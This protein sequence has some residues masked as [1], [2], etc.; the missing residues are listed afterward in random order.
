MVP[1]TTLSFCLLAWPAVFYPAIPVFEMWCDLLNEFKD[2]SPK[3]GGPF[4]PYI[5][6]SASKGDGRVRA[7]S[8]RRQHSGLQF[9]STLGFPGEGPE[10]TTLVSANI[11]SLNT[12]QLWKSWGADITCLQETRI[13]KNNVRT[14]TRNIEAVGLRP[15]L[16]QLLPGLWHA[17]GT[18]KTPCGGTA[19]LGPDVAITPFEPKHDQTG[20]FDCLFQTKRFAAAWYQVTSKIQALILCVYA[21]TG[22][23]SDSRVHKEN[24]KMFADIL[25]LVA[26]FGDIPVILS[27]DFQAVPA[28]YESLAGALNFHGWIDPLSSTDEWGSVTR[29]YTYSK[30]CSFSGA[31]EGCTSIDGVLLNKVAFCAMQDVHVLEHFGRQHRPIKVTFRWA[32][33]LQ[34]GF[35]LHKFA[36]ID[37]TQ[38]QAVPWSEDPSPLWQN[39]FEAAFH[40]ASDHELKWKV[41]NEFFQKSLLNEGGQWGKG[42]RVR[43][44]SPQFV[45]KRICPKQLVTR[46]AATQVSL[47]LY[48]LIRRLD[49]LFVRLSRESGSPQDVFNTKRLA[50]RTFNIVHKLTPSIVW[51]TPDSPTLVEVFFVRRWAEQFATTLDSRIR[52]KRIQSWK[53]KIQE[54]AQGGCAYIF[55]HLRQKAQDEPPNLVLDSAGQIITQPEDAIATPIKML[56][57]VWPYIHGKQV[58]ADL[59]P[60]SAKDLYQVI[61]RRKPHVAPGL[62]G[63]R[64]QE[65]QMLHPSCFHALALFFQSLEQSKDPLPQALVN[66]KQVILNKPGTASPMNKRLITIIPPLLLAY[67]GAR[68]AQLQ[69]WQNQAFPNAIVGGVKH[70]AMSSL[71]NE[72]RLEL[73]VANLDQETVCGIKIDKSKAFDRILPQFAACLFVAFGIPIYVVSVFLRFYQGLRKHMAYRSW[74]TPVGTTHP[75]GV[76]QGCSFSILAMNAYNKVWYH[77]IENLPG[78]SVRAYID[79]AYLW[80]RILNLHHL[81]TAIRVTRVWDALVGQKLNPDK[82]SLWS[83]N[84]SGRKQLKLA[85]SDFA[86]VNEFEVLGARIYTSSNSPFGFSDK[87]LK[88][89]LTDI[90]NIAVLPVPRATKSFL[91]GAKVI[92]RLTYGAHI[93]RIPKRALDQIQNAIVRC[94]WFGRPKWRSKWLVQAVLSKPHRT[95]PTFACAYHIVIEALRACFLQ[96]DLFPKLLRTFQSTQNLPHSLAS[97]LQEACGTLGIQLDQCMRL[98]AFGSQP[99]CFDQLAPQDARR[100]LQAICRHACYQKASTTPRKDFLK[101]KGIFDH[102]L[103]GISLA[104]GRDVTDGIHNSIRFESVVVGCCLTNDR[105]AA[106]GWVDTPLCRFCKRTKE[107]MPHLIEC[108]SLHQNI[109]A[110]VPHQLGENF[111]TLGHIEHPFFIARKRLLHQ[112]SNELIFTDEFCPG[113]PTPLWTDGSV[114]HGDNFWLATGSFAIIDANGSTVSCGMVNHWALSSFVTELWAIFS[115][116]SRATSPVIVYSDCQSAVNQI[117]DFL[118][119]GC[120]Q[121]TWL[122]QKWWGRFRELVLLRRQTHPQPFQTSWIPAHQLEEVAD[123]LLTESQALLCGTTVQHILLNR[124]ADRVAKRLAFRLAPV[125]SETFNQA[126]HAAYRH[127]QWLVHLH[128]LLPTRDTQ[129]P[130]PAEKGVAEVPDDLTET[131]AMELYPQ[132]HWTTP[133]AKF[134]WKPKIPD[135]MPAPKSWKHGVETWTQVRKF[136][137]NLRWLCHK[138][139]SYSFTELAVAF[140]AA[141]HRIQGDQE[142]IT[143]RDLYKVIREALLYLHKSADAQPVPGIFN[144]TRPRA[145]GRILPQGCIEGATPFVSSQARV[146]LA[147]LFG[148]GADRRLE[149]WTI[150]VNDW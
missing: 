139:E 13:G 109:G 128:S 24:D 60:I 75:N 93:S 23:S 141:G 11:G 136:F 135:D 98:S 121:A 3:S 22:A 12:N 67:T 124:T 94:L 69:Q 107:S 71:Y 5:F 63:W 119:N 113:E 108:A 35:I 86:V 68:Y 82:S 122:C 129:V 10:L 39:Q 49:E 81:Q 83:N 51:A 144:S 19:I 115:A 17:N 27:G 110:P 43:A 44:A 59:P 73:D 45:N 66:V 80:R 101:P 42:P 37:T 48:K 57:V 32:S 105:M 28:S 64:T 53:R 1:L 120:I 95:E 134:S 33:L 90:D 74:T 18:T 100:A 91:I 7:A 46:C 47:D 125:C 114:I 72:V 9:D 103:T 29:P 133:Q 138:A 99:V 50:R 111:L 126:K 58:K 104:T 118:Q 15:I 25:T 142:Q 4:P 70:R 117:N 146:L 106:T 34:T 145:C 102:Q 140:H 16:G 147:K 96:P 77:L 150:P 97:R 20:L 85:F 76:A 132:W 54:S 89:A 87:A 112:Q 55:Q 148:V 84:R 65:L 78:I 79:D 130:D 61:Q 2:H 36:P 41:V 26:Q 52:L 116:F 131:Q 38:I 30:D 56:E 8:D 137:Q 149:T 127:Q 6:D 31:D 88:R 143:F 123:N 21:C 92:P 14:S 40:D 62:D